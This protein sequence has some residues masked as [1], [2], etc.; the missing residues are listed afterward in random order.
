MQGQ[1][2]QTPSPLTDQGCNRGWKVLLPAMKAVSKVKKCRLAR[3]CGDHIYGGWG[4]GRGRGEVEKGKL[5]M[6]S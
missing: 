6:L 2:G 5:V 4:R 1:V 3:L